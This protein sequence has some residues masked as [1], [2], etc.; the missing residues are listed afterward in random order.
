M[1]NN[2]L[3]SETLP[4]FH[5]LSTLH[6]PNSIFAKFNLNHRTHHEPPPRTQYKHFLEVLNR[7]LRHFHLRHHHLQQLHFLVRVEMGGLSGRLH[8]HAILFRSPLLRMRPEA[9]A[10]VFQRLWNEQH[11]TDST[12]EPYDTTA[13]GDFLHYT[14]KMNSTERREIEHGRNPHNLPFLEMSDTLRKEIQ[15]KKIKKTNT[16][17]TPRLPSVTIGETTYQISSSVQFENLFKRVYNDESVQPT[18]Q[19][20]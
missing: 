12:C 6:T 5:H 16:K 7:T 15:M 9:F 13:P 10:N 18:P 20:K 11:S 1:H 4:E 8:M 2:V 17:T 14:L 19:G 3:E